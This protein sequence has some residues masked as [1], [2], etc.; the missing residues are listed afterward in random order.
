MAVTGVTPISSGRGRCAG[1]LACRLA[2]GVT[3]AEGAAAGRGQR[4]GL[5]AR[6]RGAPFPSLPVPAPFLS[7]PGPARPGRPWLRS[8]SEAAS[9]SSGPSSAPGVGTCRSFLRGPGPTGGPGAA[10]P[11]LGRRARGV[12]VAGAGR[13]LRGGFCRT[14]RW[15]AVKLVPDGPS[16]GRRCRK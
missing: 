10:W 2:A 6:G 15:E 4:R 9:A 12:A 11:C 1:C 8:E 14:R 3:W 7:G 13:R 16:G 5:A